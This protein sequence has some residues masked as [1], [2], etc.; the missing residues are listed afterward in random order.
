MIFKH[1]TLSILLQTIVNLYLLELIQL[2]N[3]LISQQQLLLLIILFLFR[4][5]GHFHI[6]GIVF[7]E[8]V[9]A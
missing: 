5:S 8:H 4:T 1:G 7:I 6:C 9:L 3:F 2:I